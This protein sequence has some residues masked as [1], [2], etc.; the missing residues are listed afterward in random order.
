MVKAVCPGATLS[1]KFWKDPSPVIPTLGK[2]QRSIT[3]YK[4]KL[5]RRLPGKVKKKCMVMEQL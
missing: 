4:I 5:L 2:K 3:R 1:F